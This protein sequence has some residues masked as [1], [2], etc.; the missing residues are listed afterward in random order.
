MTMYTYKM[1]KA[2]IKALKIV[3]VVGTSP[4]NAV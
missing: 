3:R 2:T 1:V 4:V